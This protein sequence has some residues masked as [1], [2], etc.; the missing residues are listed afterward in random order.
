MFPSFIPIKNKSTSFNIVDVD[1][2]FSSN[3]EFE[4]SL[5]TFWELLL[6]WPKS[7]SN[8]KK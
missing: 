2:A 3:P 6:L 4:F 5:K 1:F 7:E 8:I